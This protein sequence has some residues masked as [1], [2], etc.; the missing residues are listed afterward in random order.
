[1][2]VCVCVCVGVGVTLV[3]VLRISALSVAVGSPTYSTLSRRPG[4][5]TAGSMISE[6]KEEEQKGEDEMGKK[7]RRR[8]GYQCSCHTNLVSNL[9]IH[10]RRR[11]MVDLC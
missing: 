2:C 10:S 4:L 3:I 1:M 7:R 8:Q 9:I 5:I 6:A 11:D